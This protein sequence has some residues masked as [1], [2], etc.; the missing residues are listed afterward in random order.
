MLPED[1]KPTT[2]QKI[3]I[4]L[5]IVL[6]DADGAVF[7]FHILMSSLGMFVHVSLFAIELLV[8]VNRIPTLLYIIKAV[9]LHYD[10]LL[11]TFLLE[12]FIIYVYAF[13]SK[14][15]YTGRF[16][17]VPSYSTNDTVNTNQ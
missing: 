17:Y 11:L 12:M 10:Q 13:F 15:A 8:F 6:L 14:E 7:L 1:E 9:Y 5:R 3:T 16:L 2:W 4:A